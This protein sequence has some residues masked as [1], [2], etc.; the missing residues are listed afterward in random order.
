MPFAKNAEIN[1][2]TV[3]NKKSAFP[4]TLTG[5]TTVVKL[6]RKSVDLMTINWPLIACGCQ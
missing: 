4:S 6:K 3:Q 5:R 2:I 1:C